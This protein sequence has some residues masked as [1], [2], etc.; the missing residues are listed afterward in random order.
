MWTWRWLT[1]WRWIR[2]FGDRQ[3]ETVGNSPYLE[4]SQSPVNQKAV[5]NIKAKRYRNLD[6]WSRT[7]PTTP[8][9]LPCGADR[10]GVSSRPFRAQTQD[11][12]VT[13]LEDDTPPTPRRGGIGK[14]RQTLP[15]SSAKSIGV[16]GG[17]QFPFSS[18]WIAWTSYLRKIRRE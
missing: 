4:I 1:G 8:K 11:Y 6:D 7:N 17:S 18:Q 3:H 5:G 10:V 2:G 16:P 9:H 14:R 15:T 13:V 12:L